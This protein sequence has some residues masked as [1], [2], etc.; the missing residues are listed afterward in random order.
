M[1]VALLTLWLVLSG[2]EVAGA[3]VDVDDE[4]DVVP[5]SA[6]VDADEVVDVDVVAPAA[7]AVPEAPEGAAAVAEPAWLETARA[8]AMA[9]TAPRPPT[10]TD[11]VIRRRRRRARSR[12]A[13]R[14]V[15]VEGAM[16]G[17]SPRMG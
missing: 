7:A 15:G 17:V 9:P 2:A 10:P 11:V 6:A 4:V 12:W 13:D 3:S 16:T 1:L 5:G 14:S 8:A